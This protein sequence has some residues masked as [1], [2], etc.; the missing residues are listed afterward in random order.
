MEGGGG[1][2]VISGSAFSLQ[3]KGESSFSG[4]EGKKRGHTLGFNGQKEGKCLVE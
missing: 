4:G 2:W 1:K 3:R